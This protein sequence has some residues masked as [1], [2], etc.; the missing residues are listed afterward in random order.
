MPAAPGAARAPRLL[1]VVDSLDAGGAERHVADLAG[2][3]SRE[4][5]GVVVACSVAGPLRGLLDREGVPVR[6]V[7]GR[8]VKRRV[9]LPYARGLGALL[10]EGRFDLAHAHVYAS[11]GAAAVACLA[12]GVPFVVTEHTEATWQG[13]KEALV[14]RLVYRRAARVVSVSGAIRDR[15]VARDG[16]PA[17]KISVVP[18]A[19]VVAPDPASAAPP[20]LPG[21]PLVGVV[22][23][24]Q[25]EKG[26]ADFV[27]AVARV[28]PLAPGAS[29]VVVGDGPLRGD[30]AG[31][32]GR[33]GVGGRVRFLG[34]RADPR[35][36]MGRFDAVVVPSRTEG[37]PLVVL[38]AMAAGR[39]I[40]AS[41][42]GG[43]PDQI[44][45]GKEGLLV[46][47]GNPAKLADGILALLGDPPRARSLGERARARAA[48]EFSH[49]AVVRRVEAVYGAVLETARP[50]GNPGEN[51]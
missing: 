33:L 39:P 9:S 17:E 16:V 42:V 50:G 23:R 27:E 14:S 40:V 48:S 1:L 51:P 29:F 46:P 24:L 18:N 32:A 2:A 37:S 41:N 11:A 7:L 4:G 20:D 26:V 13:R 28:A 25:P 21:G 44:R 43:I 47:P 35:E 12:N 8:L 38:E 49:A 5:Y 36:V 22:A 45:H 6:P 3:L 31:L 19:V 34:H 30:L 10:R 15:L